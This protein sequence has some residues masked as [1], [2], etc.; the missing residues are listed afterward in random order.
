MF[1]RVQLLIVQLWD[2]D[3]LLP[4]LLHEQKTKVILK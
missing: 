3:V 1:I 2:N 4:Y